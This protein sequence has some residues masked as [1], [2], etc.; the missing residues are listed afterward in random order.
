MDPTLKG[1]FVDQTSLCEPILRAL[2]EW[3]GIEEA[4]RQYIHDSDQ[5]N[6]SNLASCSI[7]FPTNQEPL[8]VRRR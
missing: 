5:G 8:A 1:P 3:F 4:D 6:P 2:S 7:I